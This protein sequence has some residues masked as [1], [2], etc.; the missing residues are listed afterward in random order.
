VLYVEGSRI[1]AWKDRGG[2][3]ARVWP[4]RL[5]AGQYA[6]A[7]L[8]RPGLADDEAVPFR[9]TATT[10]EAVDREALEAEA[11]RRVADEPARYTKTSLAD[12]LGG[13]HDEARGVVGRLIAERRIGPDAP[14]A[15]LVIEAPAGPLQSE[16]EP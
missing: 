2:D 1:V 15:R 3:L 4:S 8:E 9:I 11:L 13:N 10:P 7:T 16:L 12:A 6:Y 14:R 5:G